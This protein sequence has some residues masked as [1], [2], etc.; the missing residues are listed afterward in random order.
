MLV[1]FF[2]IKC[3]NKVMDTAFDILLDLLEKLVPNGTESYSNHFMF[4]KG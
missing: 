3:F 2:H 4:E 1:H